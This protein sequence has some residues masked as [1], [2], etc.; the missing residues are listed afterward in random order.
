[1]PSEVCGRSRFCSRP[2][3]GLNPA[4]P[5]VQQEPIASARPL[6]GGGFSTVPCC[7]F[8]LFSKSS[9]WLQKPRLVSRYHHSSTGSLTVQ[10]FIFSTVQQSECKSH[11][12][13]GKKKQ[14]SAQHKQIENKL[15]ST[16]LVFRRSRSTFNQTRTVSLTR[17]IIQPTKRSK[18]S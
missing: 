15:V 4:V 14:I 11:H 18:S 13:E 6:I 5:T 3:G 12:F 2:M 10:T 8:F 16:S 1:M 17:R 7:P 9:C